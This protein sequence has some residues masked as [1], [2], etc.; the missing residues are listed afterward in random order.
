MVKRGVFFF[1]V[2][3]GMF[4]GR[5]IGMA[6]FVQPEA[7]RGSQKWIQKLIN[8][9]SSLLD[10][11]LDAILGEDKIQWLSPLKSDDYAEYRDDAFLGLLGVKLD[12]VSLNEFWPNRGPQWDAL[13][14]SSSGKFFLVEAKS[15]IPELM[16]TFSGSS[17]A[18]ISKILSSLQETKDYFCSKTDFVWS[19]TFYQYTNRLAHLYLFR[20]NRLD[21]Y[22]VD[23]YFLGDSEM[24]GPKTVDEWQGAIRLVRSCLGLREHLL[25]K[26]VVDVFID[27]ASLK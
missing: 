3:I 2:A 12:V 4:L 26:C 6:R 19:K 7:K 21:A 13:G 10:S 25:R 1:K 14:K 15:H 5:L 22:L 18:S 24:D 17:Q 27:T 16:S 23:V 8:E 11:K 9:K 20:K